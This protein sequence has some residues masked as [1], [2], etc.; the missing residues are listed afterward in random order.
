MISNTKNLLH[1]KEIRFTDYE[2]YNSKFILETNILEEYSLN[3]YIYFWK[4]KIK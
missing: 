4:I 2:D 1:F 3:N